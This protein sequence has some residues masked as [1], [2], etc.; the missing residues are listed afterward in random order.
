M[1]IPVSH[2]PRCLATMPGDRYA[3]N[4]GADAQNA[5]ATKLDQAESTRKADAIDR[6]WGV[7]PESERRLDAMLRETQPAAVPPPDTPLRAAA[8]MLD[9]LHARACHHD[10]PRHLLSTAYGAVE[11]AA[12]LS[13]AEAIRVLDEVEAAAAEEAA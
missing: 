4:C 11:L 6:R 9:R 2:L 3:C 7:D 13:P 8:R 12:T 10:S 5:T 1:T